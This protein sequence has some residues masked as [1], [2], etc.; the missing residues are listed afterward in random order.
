M[1]AIKA[2]IDFILELE[3]L[4]AV[5]RQTRPVGLERKENSAE[6]SWQTTMAALVF[7][8]DH[9]DALKVLKMLLIHD[10]VE[11]DAGDVFVY[12][13]AARK[14]AEQVERKAAL[15]LFGMLPS[16]L[17]KEL[18]E[19]WV[20]FEDRASPEAEFAKAMDRVCPVIQNINSAPSS[21]TDHGITEQQAI[22]KNAEIMKVDPELWNCLR[23]GIEG[24]GLPR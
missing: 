9:L 4:K 24:A 2:K 8:P 6:H 14:A 19:L 3:K 7:M 13:E 15:R 11:I 22:A 23:A 16:P 1:T 12:D 17:D 21:W 20:E 5:L 18:H 10:I